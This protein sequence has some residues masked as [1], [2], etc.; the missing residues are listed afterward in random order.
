[1]LTLHYQMFNIS[2]VLRCFRKCAKM[3]TYESESKC[4][5]ESHD[6]EQELLHSSIA[7]RILSHLSYT[8]GERDNRYVMWVD[9]SNILC[10]V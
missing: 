2:L 3:R 1:M 5:S 4:I 6:L 7:T 8:L 9:H 10:Y